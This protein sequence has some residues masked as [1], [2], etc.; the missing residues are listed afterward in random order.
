V[1]STQQTSKLE[2]NISMLF[3]SK[4]LS[5]LMPFSVELTDEDV[6]KSSGS[7][8]VDTE[9]HEI[10]DSYSQISGVT[11]P[12]DLAKFQNTTLP[13][14]VE[15]GEVSEKENQEEN[16]EFRVSIVG[17]ISKVGSGVGRSDNE[18]QFIFC[19]K[20]PVDFPKLNR[21]LNEVWRKYEMKQKPAFIIDCNIS[22]GYLD[23][24][25]TPDKREIIIRN[26]AVLLDK[27]RL[28]IDELYS[29]VKNTFIKSHPLITSYL[30]ENSVS[31]FPR[32]E[33]SLASPDK[34]AVADTH[35][36]NETTLLSAESLVDDSTV[37]VNEVSLS[38]DES[39]QFVPDRESDRVATVLDSGF[40]SSPSVERTVV[41]STSDDRKL[42]SDSQKPLRDAKAISSFFSSSS[43]GSRNKYPDLNR[44]K[45]QTSSAPAIRSYSHLSDSDFT[46]QVETKSTVI[47][48]D[49]KTVE[50]EKYEYLPIHID[51]AD[52]MKMDI[53][54]SDRPRLKERIWS[55]D[56]EEVLAQY[57][58]FQ[59][60][61]AQKKRLFAESDDAAAAAA[62]C[63]EMVESNLQS[64]IFKTIK[65]EV[66]YLECVFW[67]TTFSCFHLGL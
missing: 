65:K 46:R 2:E 56:T 21:V 28:H 25:V 4:F 26:E 30:V 1:L 5:T 44:S 42:L 29:P 53:P 23:V 15:K 3:G 20:R 35:E 58:E 31:S 50:A 52:E 8:L 40:S 6:L 11:F 64:D 59:K 43:S 63:E 62:I 34:R 22:K 36:Q 39:P 37:Q 17:W 66:S 57:E 16:P 13:T 7:D 12:C 32:S 38:E 48:K 14:A 61:K 9:E 55:F 41:W 67:R 18:R 10:T 33:I 27:L 60:T 51:G 24:N 49:M 54:S 19:N 45:T 47:D